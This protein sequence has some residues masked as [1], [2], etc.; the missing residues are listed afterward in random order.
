MVCDQFF[1]ARLQSNDAGSYDPGCF[2]KR[3]C[4]AVLTIYGVFLKHLQLFYICDLLYY[5]SV[6]VVI[7]FSVIASL[8]VKAVKEHFK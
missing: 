8:S 2:P 6:S 1:C 5:F 4:I 3:L 7:P